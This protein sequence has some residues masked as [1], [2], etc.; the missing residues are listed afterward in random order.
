MYTIFLSLAIQTRSQAHVAE[1]QVHAPTLW[2]ATPIEVL[3]RD[4]PEASESPARYEPTEQDWKDYAEWSEFHERV[5]MIHEAEQGA[6]RLA[7]VGAA[8]D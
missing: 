2:F 8:I 6:S 4:A 5:A 7:D 3:A 1:A